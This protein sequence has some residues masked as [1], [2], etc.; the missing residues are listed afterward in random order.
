MASS[1][2]VSLYQGVRIAKSD[3]LLNIGR[4]DAVVKEV[5]EGASGRTVYG[6]DAN[7]F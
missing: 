1:L 3:Q 2:K 6:V 5:K 4:C 7:P